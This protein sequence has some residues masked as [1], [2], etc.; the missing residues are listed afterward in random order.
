MK[1]IYALGTLLSTSLLVA[2]CGG[3]GGSDGD[4]TNTTSTSTSTNTSGN[5]STTVNNPKPAP[6]VLATAEGVYEGVVSNGSSHQ[7]IVLDDGRYYTLYGRSANDMFLVSGLVQGTGV[8]FEGTFTS[9]DL[10]DYYADGTVVGGTL[11]AGYTAGETFNGSVKEAGQTINFLG[12]KLTSASY[13]YST[14]AKLANITGTWSMTTLQGDAV[15][16]S[17]QTTGAFSATSS[18][19]S[20]SG[21]IR[22]RASGK[23]VFDVSLQFG[24]APCALPNQSASGIAVEYVTNTGSRQLIIAGTNT[25]RANGTVMFGLR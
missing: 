12:T 10:R 21:T 23:N 2:A 16:F 20:F 8:S 22:P 17:L 1:K 13:S 7:T 11:S 3:G 4:S 24:A 15:S 25:S 6:T 5:T 14:A 9:T 18:G 19:C